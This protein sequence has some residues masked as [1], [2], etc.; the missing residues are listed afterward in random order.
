MNAY[1][2]HLAGLLVITPTLHSDARGLFFES[3]R[4]TLYSDLGIEERF[5]QSNISVSRK[6]VLRGLHYQKDMGQ[7][8]SI[9]EGIVYDV[10]VDIRPDSSTFKKYFS[11]ELDA[12]KPQ[13]IYMPPGFAHG[14]C[15][16]S[17]VAIMHYKCTQ[18]Y[19]P[20]EEGRLR[21]DDPEIG[22]D[23]PLAGDY[24]ISENDS[25]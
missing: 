11:I 22:I 20:N 24:I 21:W 7:L 2:A 10:L 17:D 4:D 1:E 13:Q 19:K 6:G 12:Q 3:W 5:V 8:I 9:V 15:V 25:D 23:W 14:F 18:Y 16:L